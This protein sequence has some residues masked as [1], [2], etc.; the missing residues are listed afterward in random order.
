MKWE[1]NN[2]ILGAIIW[3]VTQENITL[4]HAKAQTS[5]YISA[6]LLLTF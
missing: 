3:A 6:P 5:L 1:E 2:S 4:L